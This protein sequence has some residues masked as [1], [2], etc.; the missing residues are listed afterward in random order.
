MNEQSSPGAAPE[1]QGMSTL[2]KV[3][4]GCGV[5]LVLA[6]IV[7]GILGRVVCSKAKE[8]A[9]DYKENPAHAMA[10]AITAT[11]PD[12]EIVETDDDAG[13]VTIR[14]EKT[15]EQVTVD[16]DDIK[17]GKLKIVTDEGEFAISGDRERGGVTIET[18]EGTTKFGGGGDVDDL[19]GWV[20][21]PRGV[22]PAD[23]YTVD[24]PKAETGGYTYSTRDDLSEAFDDMAKLLESEGYDI[25]H[26]QVSSTGE[27]KA[28][29]LMAGHGDTERQIHVTGEETDTG[30]TVH[31]N[32]V[33]KK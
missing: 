23:V 15:G 4:I 12:L 33:G 27:G 10:K 18:E 31:V 14:N 26:R 7:G 3:G 30:A 13:T 32:F 25:Q 19:P 21:I 29:M 6:I 20:P 24:Q 22:A 17:E 28:G 2:A 5:L 16:F 1:K 11:N 9:E 8:F